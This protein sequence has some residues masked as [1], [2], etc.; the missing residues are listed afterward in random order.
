M[1]SHYHETAAKVRDL[2]LF[3]SQRYSNSLTNSVWIPHTSRQLGTATCSVH[4]M[5]QTCAWVAAQAQGLEKQL[6][7]MGQAKTI[8]GYTQSSKFHINKVAQWVCLSL[9]R[10][11][12]V[13]LVSYDFSLVHNSQ[14][15]NSGFWKMVMEIQLV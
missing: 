14:L 5:G 4:Q 11:M 10:S 3:T 2:M 1:A 6:N 8:E 13:W 15:W 12:D 7:Q 9:N